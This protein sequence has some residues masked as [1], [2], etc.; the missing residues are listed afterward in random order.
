MEGA[1]QSYQEAVKLDP[2]FALAWA[3][4]SCAEFG[5]L[6]GLDPTP[7]R[8]AAAK[9]A[10]DHAI[11]LDPNLPE[12]HL[13]LGYYRYY[14]QRDFTGALA[15]FRKLNRVFRIT[16]MSS[17]A[18]ALIQRRLGHWD[19]AIA[20]VRRAVELDPRNIDALITLAS[21]SAPCAVFRKL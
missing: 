5:V 3:Y 7:A 4:L 8:L 19:E 11:A 10:L 21:C 1:I 12:T 13:A 9:D 15:E 14:G 16:L 6:G 18:I 17:M 20:A 2:N